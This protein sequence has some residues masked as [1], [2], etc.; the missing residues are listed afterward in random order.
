MEEIESEN[1]KI[2]IL[3]STVYMSVIINCILVYHIPYWVDSWIKGKGEWWLRQ[4]IG[5]YNDILD[6][7]EVTPDTLKDIY[8]KNLEKT[9]AVIKNIFISKGK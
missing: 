3:L 9:T 2:I 5:F 4:A 7:E 1:L 6:R 8:D